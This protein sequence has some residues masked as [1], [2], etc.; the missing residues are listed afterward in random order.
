MLGAT[1]QRRVKILQKAL[2][3]LHLRRARASRLPFSIGAQF[4]MDTHGHLLDEIME[5]VE[6]G[7]GTNT[8][9]ETLPK[10]IGVTSGRTPIEAKVYSD[11]FQHNWANNIAWGAPGEAMAEPEDLEELCEIVKNASAVRVLGRGHSFVPV[12]EVTEK[13]G[14]MISL[15]KMNRILELN[16][17]RLTVTV[18]GGIT[19]SQLVGFLSSDERPYALANVQSHPG[20]TVAVSFCA[21]TR[22]SPAAVCLK[23]LMR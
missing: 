17:E 4:W 16:E 5:D 1:R 7:E 20:F 11:Y 9:L 19:Y 3:A 8:F 22:H 14:T 13:G 23:E 2:R 18:E 6:S 15:N 21:T 10:R 12:C